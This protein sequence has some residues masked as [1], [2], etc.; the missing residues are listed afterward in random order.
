MLLQFIAVV[1]C[2]EFDTAVVAVS[3]NCYQLFASACTLD[4][5][6]VI[7]SSACDC[8]TDEFIYD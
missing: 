2:C 5:G 7:D 3:Y 4:V 1:L 6:D 8:Y